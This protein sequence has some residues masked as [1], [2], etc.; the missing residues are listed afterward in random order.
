M[1]KE[2][3]MYLYALVI[4]FALGLGSVLNVSFKTY[5]HK[6]QCDALKGAYINGMCLDVKIFKLD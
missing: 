1:L 5:S 4:M 2:H 6:E 3:N